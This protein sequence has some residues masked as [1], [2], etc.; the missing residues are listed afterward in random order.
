MLRSY[1]AVAVALAPWRP[2]RIS[3]ENYRRIIW[4]GDAVRVNSALGSAGRQFGSALSRSQSTSLPLTVWPS[5]ASLCFRFL[6]EQK[7]EQ[8]EVKAAT[9]CSFQALC[10]QLFRLR[11]RST[12]SH[13]TSRQVAAGCKRPQ[14]RVSH[15]VSQ[16][17][18]SRLEPTMLSS[19]YCAT[20]RLRQTANFPSNSTVSSGKRNWAKLLLGNKQQASR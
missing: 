20:T 8:D 10:P 9:C 16:S 15:S 3:V 17:H 19:R 7:Q 5:L 12:A 18:D 11:S 13:L 14:R 1:A 4:I 2:Q 6:A